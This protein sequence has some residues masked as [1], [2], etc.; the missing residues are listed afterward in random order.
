MATMGSRTGRSADD[1]AILC[2]A[3]LLGVIERWLPLIESGEERDRFVSAAASFR[4]AA[5]ELPPSH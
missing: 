5:H 1:A 3:E 2:Y 4:R